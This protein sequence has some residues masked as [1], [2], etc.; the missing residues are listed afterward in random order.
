MTKKAE[1]VTFTIVT[2]IAI[3]ASTIILLNEFTGITGHVTFNLDDLSQQ[4]VNNEIILA[5]NQSGE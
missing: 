5:F 1:I 4:S 3:L 2:L